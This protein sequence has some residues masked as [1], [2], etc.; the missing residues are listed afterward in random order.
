[1][2]KASSSM[3]MYSGIHRDFEC[4][5]HAGTGPCTSAAEPK[6]ARV[7]CTRPTPASSKYTVTRTSGSAADTISPASHPP[8]GGG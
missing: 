2:P 8:P 7:Q 3:R 5:S 6:T 1:M 4:V